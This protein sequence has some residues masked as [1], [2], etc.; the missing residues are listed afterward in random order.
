MRSGVGSKLT[1]SI[2]TAVRGGSLSIL[3]GGGEIGFWTGG[4]NG[5]RAEEI[6]EAIEQLFEENFVK[7]ELIGLIAVSAGPGSATG[8]KI[9]LATARGLAAAFNCRLIE[10]SVLDAL[11]LKANPE[12][13]GE[14]LTA[15]PVGKELF[16]WRAAGR[17]DISE[18]Q[19]AAF[20]ELSAELRSSEYSQVVLPD[21]IFQ[22]VSNSGGCLLQ[23][24]INAGNNLAGL[25]GEAGIKING[26]D[27]ESIL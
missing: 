22:A 20:E 13:E 21:S 6:L 15:V 11:L 5:C 12:T 8:I 1:L 16:A 27:N 3:E 2:E 17:S 18:I 24:I 19:I 14:I 4:A 23:T 9:G 7:R 10:V 25:I 26:S